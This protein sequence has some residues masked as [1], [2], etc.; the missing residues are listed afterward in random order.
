M[1]KFAFKKS[2]AKNILERISFVLCLYF[3]YLNFHFDA[4][5]VF[6][7]SSTIDWCHVSLVYG[8]VSAVTD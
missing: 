6:A 3:S 7:Y 8:E 1:V 2:E 5:H 4:Q